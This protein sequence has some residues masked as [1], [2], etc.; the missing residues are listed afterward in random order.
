[1][2]FDPNWMCEKRRRLGPFNLIVSINVQLGLAIHL[3][4]IGIVLVVGPFGFQVDWN[5][6]YWD[7]GI[8]RGWGS[9]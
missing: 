1:M 2:R 8:F 5:D 9:Q 6:W 4:A 3:A 7:R